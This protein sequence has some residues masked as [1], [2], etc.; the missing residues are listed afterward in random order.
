M[1]TGIQI[2]YQGSASVQLDVSG[3]S[4]LLDSIIG[5]KPITLSQNAHMHNLETIF[6]AYSATFIT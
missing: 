1:S 2:I 4:T 6:F 3:V 5:N